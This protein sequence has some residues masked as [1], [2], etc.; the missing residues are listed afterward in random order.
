MTNI[1]KTRFLSWT[2]LAASL[3]LP[4][5]AQ[6]HKPKIIEFAG[7]GAATVT[8]PA[9]G[10][11]CG[12]F[13]YD[14]NAEGVI[15]GSYTDA[16]IVQRGFLRTPNGQI[17][18]FDAPGAGL[19]VGLDQGTLA[20]SINDLGVIAGQFQDSS[21]EFHGFVRYPDGSFTTFD[22]PG[23]G[24]GTNTGTFAFSINLAGA[25]AGT[26]IDGIGVYHGF[27]RSRH[28]EI[29]SFDLPGPA[30]DYVAMFPRSLNAEGA[31]TGWY[32]DADGYHG[33]LREP[34]GKIT[35]INA[36]GASRLGTFAM[37]ITLEGT[38]AGYF[39]DSNNLFYGFVRTRDGNFTTLDVPGAGT[40]R[41]QGT[42]AYS[43]NLFGAV[44]GWFIDA[45]NVQHGFSRSARGTFA[46]IDPPGG[47]GGT[48]PL[49]INGEGAVAGVYVV[50]NDSLYHSFLWKP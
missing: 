2:L 35:E 11:Y 48:L 46:T 34:D 25:I 7:P 3:A 24:T 29:T 28:G 17:I 15:V 20:Y 41:F 32:A 21:Y 8:P 16:N 47:L 5:I 50:T 36:P 22:A 26:Y 6:L 33:F 1:K 18:P 49:T 13:A 23:A 44:T 43:I 9:C 4:A 10:V 39:L 40:G 14:N 38:I 12:T 45:N 37:S 42:F 27:V 19:G 31:I 30:G